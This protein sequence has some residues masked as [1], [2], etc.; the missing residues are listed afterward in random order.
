VSDVDDGVAPRPK[1]TIVFIFSKV[2]YEYT[3]QKPTALP[4]TPVTLKW[5][6]KAKAE[7]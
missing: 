2:I 5:D 6:V 1:E 3:P 7:F 4:D